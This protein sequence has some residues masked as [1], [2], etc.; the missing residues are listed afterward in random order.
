MNNLVLRGSQGSQLTE[1]RSWRR[2]VR[3]GLVGVAVTLLS[4][5]ATVGLADPAQAWTGS[6]DVDLFGFASC[7]TVPNA[8][9]IMPRATWVYVHSTGETA[10]QPVN[11]WTAFWEA[12]LHTIPSQGSLVD[13]WIH[14]DVPGI[15][16]EWRFV[17]TTFVSRPVFG[18]AV[19][20]DWAKA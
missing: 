7:K 20:Q 2:L 9:D 8:M 13:L 5:V 11:Y 15:G 18:W 12:H 16:P 10:E 6:A 17:R 4:A 19:R 3:R 14:C 1:S